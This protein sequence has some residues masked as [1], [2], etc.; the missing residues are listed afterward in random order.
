MKGLLI[1]IL[2]LSFVVN[3]VP[4][5]SDEKVKYK[6]GELKNG[7]CKCPQGKKIVNGNCI[8]T[9]KKCING[10]YRL[11]K[12]ICKPGFTLKGGKKCVKTNC[13]GG[14]FKN[15]KCQCPVGIT[16]KDNKCEGHLHKKCLGGIIKFGKC[17]CPQGTKLLNGN[18]AKK[19]NHNG[20]F[21]NGKRSPLTLCRSGQKYMNGRCSGMNNRIFSKPIIRKV[22]WFL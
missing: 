18:C 21:T 20:I 16:L 7:I 11:G 10:S 14:T 8:D 19:Y 13:E 9:L 4:K 1:L 22:D 3:A 17:I 15:W 2:L 5:N 6:D 12:C